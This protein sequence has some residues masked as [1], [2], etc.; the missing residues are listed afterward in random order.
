MAR[1]IKMFLELCQEI[2]K[3]F[4]MKILD[5]LI[6]CRDTDYTDEWKYIQNSKI[7]HDL[8]NTDYLINSEF[9]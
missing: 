1:Y 5:I 6:I 7:F 2:F 4:I 9:I 3:C 8:W